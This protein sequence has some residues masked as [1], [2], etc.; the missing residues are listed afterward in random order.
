MFRFRVNDTGSTLKGR[1]L[2]RQEDYAFSA[3]PVNHGDISIVIDTLQLGFDS[4]TMRALQVWGFCPFDQ[5]HKRPLRTPA[6]IRGELIL[7]GEIESGKVIELPGTREWLRAFDPETG[8]F[9]R[10]N[11]VT[12]SSDAAVEFFTDAIAVVD[13]KDR[14]KAIWLRP[15][16]V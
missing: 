3:Q 13:R 9:C 2:Y 16:F 12:S 6:S 7:L 11:E 14:L 15:A 10:G 5:R 8:W 1:I 4:G